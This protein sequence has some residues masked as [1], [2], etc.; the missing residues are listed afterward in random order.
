MAET[1]DDLSAPLGQNRER[2]KRRFRLPFSAMQVLAAL[3]GLFLVTFI[4]FALFNDNPL[5]GEP[6]AHVAIREKASEE[7]SAPPAANHEHAEKAVPA[8]AGPGEQ[9]TV[10]IIDGSSGKRQDVVVGG[11]AE[12]SESSS[13]PVMVTGIDQRLLEKTRYGMIPIV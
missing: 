4:G 5:G 11:G 3:L 1:V 6:I 2:R 12:K 10:T 8:Q 7:K 13:A 9:K